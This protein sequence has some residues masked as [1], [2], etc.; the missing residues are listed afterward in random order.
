MEMIW[1][2]ENWYWVIPNIVLFDN[3]LTDKQKL[4]YCLISSLCAEKWYCRA[5]NEYL[6]K[7]LW[8]WKQ[9]ISNNIKILIDLW[10]IESEVSQNYD[11]KIIIV[12]NINYKGDIKKI[13]G[14]YNKNYKGDITKV[15]D[16]NIIEKDKLILQYNSYDFVEEFIDKE[17]WTI[18]YLMNKDKDYIKKQNQYVDKLIKQWYDIETIKTVLRYIKQDEFWNKNILSIKKLTEKNKDW[19]PYILVMIEKIKNYKPKCIDLDSL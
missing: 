3:N 15:I 10:Y 19:I 1:I 4:L 2:M 6:W 9:C 16:N 14:G 12:S 13:I 17:N 11:R 8:V 18:K 5:T 7:K